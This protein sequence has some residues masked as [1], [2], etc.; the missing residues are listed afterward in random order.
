MQQIKK[1][2]K[3]K[4]LKNAIIFSRLS[5]NKEFRIGRNKMVDLS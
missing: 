1:E 2:L 4:L 5:L 3:K